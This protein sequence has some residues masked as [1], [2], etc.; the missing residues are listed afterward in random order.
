MLLKLNLYEFKLEHQNIK[1]S[2]DGNH[3]DNSYRNTQKKMTKEFKTFTIKISTKTK[4]ND[5]G[6]KEQKSYKAFRKQHN[7]RSA[8]FLISNCCKCK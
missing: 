4:D 3:K 2:H 7:D 1:V 6:Y 5:I 8:S